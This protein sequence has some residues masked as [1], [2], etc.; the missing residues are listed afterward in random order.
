[1]REVKLPS[2]V[3]QELGL[4]SLSSCERRVTSRG[5]PTFA[6]PSLHAVIA[7]LLEL[8]AQIKHLLLLENLF[9]RKVILAGLTASIRRQAS[10]FDE[11]VER[12]ERS[13]LVSKSASKSALPE[14]EV[15]TS[16]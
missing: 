10:L 2:L 8:N 5:N 7:K 1:M 6:T 16:L 3:Q 4:V 13:T 12:L 9:N 11:Q 15:P 14:G